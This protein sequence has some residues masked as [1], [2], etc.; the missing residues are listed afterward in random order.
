MI[1]LNYIE[2]YVT[3]AENLNFTKTANHLYITQPAL[4]RHISIIEEMVDA[5]LF[6]RN[7][8]GVS[9]TPAGQI[10]YESFKE[11]LKAFNSANEQIKRLTS[12]NDGIDISG[13]L[14]INSPYYWAEKYI[15]P[16]KAHFAKT[17]P[18]VEVR[19]KSFQ[20][21]D[22]FI[23]MCNGEADIAIIS[24][25]IS[26]DEINDQICR[27][28]FARE[29][30]AVAMSL[31]HRLAGR[32]SVRLDE[33]KDDLFVSV[34]DENDSITNFTELVL[35]LMRKR[36]VEAKKV[37]FPHQMNTLETAI[38]QSGGVSV[39]PLCFGEKTINLHD[40][41]IIPLEDPDCVISM[42]CYYRANNENQALP[43]F[44]RSI[45]EVFPKNSAK[46]D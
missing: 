26:I 22:C 18:N 37:R 36:G 6:I 38:L 13:T 20:P 16:I 39:V 31:E 21:I 14:K 19:A 44:L 43:L 33:F 41:T 29:R 11:I 5:K 15:D 46:E 34:E 2:E 7:T 32:S 35:S 40:S 3:L 10:V 28:E 24:M 30:L 4:S 8:K 42:N 12:C 23:G 9:I 45:R 17:F 25:T 27:Y 1:K